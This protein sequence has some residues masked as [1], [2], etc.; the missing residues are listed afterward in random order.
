MAKGYPRD[1]ED[2]RFFPTIG[3]NLY[4]PATRVFQDATWSTRP[5]QKLGPDTFRTVS[6]RPLTSVEGWKAGAA[7][8]WRGWTGMDVLLHDCAKMKVIGVTVKN[9][10]GNGFAEYLGEGDN[11]YSHCRV[12]PMGLGPADATEEPLSS[13][14]ADGLN[15]LLMRQRPDRGGLLL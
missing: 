7:V 14:N 15:S 3:L 8:F 9:A 10:S 13:S 5:V 2:L 1:V 6:G 11:F 4:D 12:H